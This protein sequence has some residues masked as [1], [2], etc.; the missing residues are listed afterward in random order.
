MEETI[1]SCLDRLKTCHSKL[2][3]IGHRVDGRSDI[4]SLGVVLY[5]MLVG[6][7][8]FRGQT[9]TELIEQ[10]ATYEARPLRQYDDRIPKELE[11]ICHKAIAKREKDRYFTAKEF[12]ED[13]RFF[14]AEQC[15]TQ[16]STSSDS[17]KS[18]GLG[19]ATSAVDSMSA[20]AVSGSSTA[21]GPGSSLDSH[22][23][24]IVPKGLRSF[25]AHDADFFLELL[26][27]PRDR[28]GLPDS[29]RFWKT[30]IEATDPADTFS[31]G[32]IYGPSGCGKSSLVKA[33]LLPR[34]SG[35]PSWRRHLAHRRP[36]QNT[37]SISK[38]PARC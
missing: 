24:K 27:G 14:L 34:V 6:R 25:D 37:D 15:A 2:D 36:I 5:E 26:P 32:L 13:L 19:P 7:R 8:P 10:L 38:P 35:Q 21:I 11:R 1:S 9:R 18:I 28:N 31:V 4:F 29:I 17:K 3:H 22:P 23:L 30:R 33:G 20:G 16:V 12:A